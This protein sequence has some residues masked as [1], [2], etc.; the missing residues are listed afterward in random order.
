MYN[1][2]QIS[3][4]VATL[5]RLH[6]RI[7]ERFPDSGL[8]KVAGE[9]LKIAEETGPILERQRRPHRFIQITAA[10]IILLILAIP[11]ASFAWRGLPAFGVRD[12][13]TVLQVTESA[14]QDIIFLSFAV[15]FVFTLETR[16]DRRGSLRELQRLRNIVHIIDMHQLTKD[17]EHL[18]SPDMRTPSSPARMLT[19]FEMSRY[20]DYCTEL[21]S[22]SSKVAAVHLQAVNDPVVLSAV[23]DIEVLS[24]N[25]TNKIWQKI[26]V[27]DA[28]RRPSGQLHG[29]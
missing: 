2:L 14:I 10:A 26:N 20:L 15:Y 11:I 29:I 5:Q 7:C 19:H 4:I 3:H 16:L 25:L 21:L 23:S 28:L 18:I 22:L 8:S 24:S 12:L 13:P 1:E 17:P 6:R 27:V 9:L